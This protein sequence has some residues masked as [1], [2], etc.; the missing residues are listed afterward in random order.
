MPE[1]DPYRPPVEPANPF[2]APEVRAGLSGRG[3]HASFG[4]EP[5][6]PGLVM[7]RAWKI[8][9]ERFWVIFGSVIG[10]FV[11]N[12]VLWAL[13]GGLISALAPPKASPE[14]YFVIM[15]VS[16]IA[17]VLFGICTASGLMYTLTKV[18]RGQ[19]ASV[20]DI[21]RGGPFIARFIGATL[22]QQLAVMGVYAGCAIPLF[23]ASGLAAQYSP[24]ASL[25][26]LVIGAIITAVV[27][28]IVAVRLYLYPFVIVDRDAGAMESLRTSYALTRG[29]VIE[30]IGLA[31]IA[32]LIAMA[33]FLAFFIGALFTD[34]FSV[35]LYPCIYVAL[36]GPAAKYSARKPSLDL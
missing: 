15:C 14:L 21:L 34:P 5:F 30:L 28:A 26:V 22:L 18:A 19:P 24:G 36:A 4:A 1:Y 7:S 16:V 32:S 12:F 10:T 8:Y 2:E 17:A 11:V 23:L 25:V 29:H 31:I 3:H 20:G 33:G 6:S 27:I 35:F 9:L 13:L